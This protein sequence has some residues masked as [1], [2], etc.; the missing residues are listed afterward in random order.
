MNQVSAGKHHD[1][2]A[3]N[4]IRFLT[5]VVGKAMHKELFGAEA[6][7]TEIIK[8]IAIPNVMMRA[9]DEETFEVGSRYL[10]IH[11]CLGVRTQDSL[12]GFVND[13][14]ACVESSHVTRAH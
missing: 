12:Y 1:A 11:A 8:N 13:R 9:A 7:L 14:K 4:C 10:A 2:L 5:L 6:T 3:T